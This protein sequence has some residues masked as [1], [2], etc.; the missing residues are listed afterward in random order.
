MGEIEGIYHKGGRSSYQGIWP[1]KHLQQKKQLRLIATAFLVTL[2]L[3]IRGGK[4][5]GLAFPEGPEKQP[6]LADED[7]RAQESLQAPSQE[8]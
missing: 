5:R 6:D 3:E 1:E 7:S 4:E 2:I 8:T